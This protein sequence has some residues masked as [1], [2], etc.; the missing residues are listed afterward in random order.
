M[1]LTKMEQNYMANMIMNVSG[2]VCQLIHYFP[3]NQSLKIIFFFFFF[4]DKGYLY[5]Q[6]PPPLPDEPPP[7]DS[8]YAGS[9]MIL[10]TPDDIPDLSSP[11]DDDDDDDDDDMSPIAESSSEA[12]T[13]D[14]EPH[15]LFIK[16]KEAHYRNAVSDAELAK[17]K[18]RVSWAISK[19]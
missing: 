18:A 6:P 5:L 14:T 11:T 8:E 4:F 10:D 17:V 7:E 1:K 2:T 19:C 12:V 16:L 9:A 13:P 15:M 3:G